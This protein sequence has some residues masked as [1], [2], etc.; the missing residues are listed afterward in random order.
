MNKSPISFLG[1]IIWLIAALFFLYE[2]F[3]RTFIGTVAHQIIP[4]LHLTPESFAL[5]GSAYYIAYAI[6][7]IPVGVLADKFG[8]KL[9]M[10]F[11]V[12]VC[13]VATWLFAQSTGFGFAFFSRFLMGFGSSFA[14]ICLLVIAVTWFPRRYFGFFAGTSQ[15]IGTM[16]PLLAGGPLVFFLSKTHGNWRLVLSLIA[17]FGVLL[18]LLILFIVRNKPR[19]GE[20]ALIYLKRPQGLSQSLKLL[21]KNSQMWYI[22]FY[23]ACVYASIVVLG[24]IW[25]T[26]YLEARGL[27]QRL[28]ADMVSLAW[29]GFAVACPLLGAFSDIARRRKPT[30]IFCSLLGL[31]STAIITYVPIHEH[32]IYGFLFFLIGMAASGQNIGFAIISEHSSLTTRA[33]GLGLNNAM[34]ILLGAI[35]PPLISLFIDVSHGA[36]LTASDF[37]I[38]FSFL[39]A[40]SVISFFIA[41]FLI[42]ETYGKPQR[43]PIVLKTG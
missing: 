13:A 23:S 28:A 34:I 15:F 4:D 37:I 38:G 41:A 2:F 1:L 32:W 11:A 16:G 25:G 43:E 9:I 14:F 30:L 17:S 5:I 20:Q 35:I 6:M 40:L 31:L 26:D 19:G 7:Q 8:V 27:T 22:A 18:A 10:I 33:F 24:A 21:F 29:F 3:L 12:L 39:P 42:K 36:H